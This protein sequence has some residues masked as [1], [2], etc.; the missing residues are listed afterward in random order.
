MTRPRSAT[1]N[2]GKRYGLGFWLHP[3][4]A[5]VAL[6]GYDAGVSFGSLHVPSA[7]LTATVIANWSDG[8]WPIAR[9]LDER[10][11]GD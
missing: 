5:A 2:G 7:D 9:M 6:E 10:F 4:S 1:N 11:G 8:A 3:T